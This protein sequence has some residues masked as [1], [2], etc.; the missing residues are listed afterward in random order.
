MMTDIMQSS[1]LV[2]VQ[3]DPG[4]AGVCLYQ[5]GT[6]TVMLEAAVIARKDVTGRV[7]FDA[8]GAVVRNAVEDSF[9]STALSPY[10]QTAVINQAR[11][12]LA[13]ARKSARSVLAAH[14]HDTTAR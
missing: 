11:R 8:Q 13:K 10:V 2:R 14:D 7:E 9:V 5:D 6:A 1:V 12:C 4:V 3:L